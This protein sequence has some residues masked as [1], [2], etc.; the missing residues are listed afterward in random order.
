MSRRARRTHIP[1]FTAKA[2][3]AAVEGDRTP[4]ELAEQFDAHPSQ[5]TSWNGAAMAAVSVSS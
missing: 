1:A 3:R 4:A 2:A 5:V